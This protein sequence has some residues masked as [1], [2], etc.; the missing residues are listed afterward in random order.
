M[1]RTA[2]LLALAAATALAQTPPSK[3]APAP[4]RPAVPPVVSNYNDLKY[5]DLRTIATP[6]V[7]SVTL[8]NGM[9]L[10]LLENHELPLVSGT[11][12]VRTG[13]AFDPPEKIGLAAI[14]A[15]VMLEGGTTDRPG[16]DLVRRFQDLGA[17][18]D[19]SVRENMLS[20]S[21]VGLK[22]NADAV[23]DALKD[24]LTAP[25]F[26]QERIDLAK[27]RAR[28]TI[29][30]R[31]DDGAAILQREFSAA[32]F[33]KNSPYGAPVEYD[34]LDRINRGDLVGFYQRYF[35]PRNLILSMEGDFDAAR[36][37]ARIE[38]LFDDWQPE[39]PA[40]PAFPEVG[41]A[42]APGK[43]LAV[44]KDALHAFFAVGQ[45]GGDYLDKD[46][47]ALEIMA[48]ILGG[49]PQGRLNQR[50]RGTVEG[51]A[52]TWAPG[53]GHPGLFQ[54][55]GA[56]ANPFFIGKVLQQVYEELSRMRLEQVSEQELKAAKSSA[57]NSMVFAFDN[58]LSILT[59]LTEYR[60][61]NFPADYTQQHQKALE[62]VT[63]ADVLRVARERL[64][65]AKMT[66]VVVGNP[67]G[68][69][70]PLE[71]LGDGPV[72]LIDLTI[73]PPKHEA[74]FGDAA[75]QRRGKQFLARA[76]QAMG[77]ADKLAAVTDYVAE[78]AYQ[79]D[80]SAGG[81]QATVTERWI[82]PGYLRQDTTMTSG[83]LSVYCDGKTGWL[84]NGKNSGALIG[85]QLKQVQS[86]LFRVLFPLMLSDRAPARKVTAL[87]DETVEIS[88]GAGQ[89]AKAVF[90]SATGLL[91]NVLYDA[92]TANGTVP[93]LETYSDYRD[94][95]GLKLPH[96]VAVSLAGRKFQDLTITSMQINT[97]LRI[98]DLDKRP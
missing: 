91:K 43:F 39:Q 38:A 85:V 74:V 45:A 30:H 41:N 44:K 80:V 29:A 12:L 6:A 5:P 68:F 4:R 72:S 67:T 20:I 50:L 88:D 92:A 71:S 17:E 98:L 63:R 9:R 53:F 54:V 25:E 47:P 24:G 16:D 8:P 36:M 2:T 78:I 35:F 13:S 89:I 26:P 75:S 70:A 57:L 10:L 48:D 46:D 3:A 76:Q 94:V 81:A 62:G 32:I 28:Y 58:Q 14:A 61:F 65:P 18:L 56:I 84:S 19:G 27:T 73:P 79:F 42:V 69:D 37:K 96:K 93:V 83:K 55:S 21:F 95:S 87:D 1:I 77:G 22:E 40:V 51:L 90:D 60:Y 7:E 11:V 33:G 82:A 15:K 86:D 52:A 34:D 66:T 97:G 23:L 31:N 49:G 64:D 59:R